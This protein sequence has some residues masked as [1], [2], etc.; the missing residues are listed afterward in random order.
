[1]DAAALSDALRLLATLD[2]G[3]T[4]IVGL[5]LVVS[6]SATALACLIGL[7]LGA[8]LAV[9]RFPGRGALTA[10]VNALMGLPPVV[11]GLTVYLLLSASGPPG[12]LQLLYTPAAMILAQCVLVVPIVAALSRET[13]AALNEE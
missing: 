13:L 5:S 6:H 4:E 7:P 3:L 1:M 10:A 9:A 12:A 2:G 8:A 11:V